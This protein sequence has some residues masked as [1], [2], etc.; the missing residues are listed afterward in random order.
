MSDKE[1]KLIVA[2]KDITFAPN[3]TA[4]NK[5]INEITISNKVAPAHNFLVRIVTPETKEALEDILKLPGAA[6][7]VV[8]KVMDEYTPEL[9]ITVKN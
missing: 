4:Y 6:L 2:G 8:S 3:V 9:E 5:Y 1:I 7:Q